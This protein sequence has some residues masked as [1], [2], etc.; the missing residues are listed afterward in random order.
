MGD[1][2]DLVGDSSLAEGEEAIKAFNVPVPLF[3]PEECSN[4]GDNRTLKC[5]AGT[6]SIAV[7]TRDGR[8]DLSDSLIQCAPGCPTSITYLYS[9]DV[10][11]FWI[12][13]KH[14]LPRSSER[15]Y[16]KIL[17]ELSR[18]RGRFDVISRVHF[19]RASREYEYMMHRIDTEVLSLY[20]MIGKACGIK[21]KA[22]H[23]DVPAV[24]SL[25]AKEES[26][27]T[28]LVSNERQEIPA[29]SIKPVSAKVSSKLEGACVLKQSVSL[30][31]TT[32]LSMVH[33]LVQKELEN[34]SV[35]NLS[36]KSLWLKKGVTLG[37]LEEFQEVENTEESGEA[38]G[39]D[40]AI[41]GVDQKF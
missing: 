1:Q 41:E 37:T 34:I 2:A 5:Q 24:I 12:H 8:F 21:P 4:C 40:A 16:L 36:P 11:E 39:T 32:S 19:A 33:A 9:E 10:L 6:K 23:V 13:L 3:C 30:M 35:A 38:S 17:E 29:Y 7:I 25:N 18:T 31:A 28:V 14:Q 15:K 26:E 27:D 22:L 20:I